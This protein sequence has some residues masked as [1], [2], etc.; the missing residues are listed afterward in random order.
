MPYK[1]KEDAKAW[2]KK[3][4]R[5]NKDNWKNPDGSWK[6]TYKDNREKRREVTNRSYY[7][8]HESISEKRKSPRSKLIKKAWLYGA[9][10]EQI[11]QL[12]KDFN[13]ECAICH[14]TIDLCV[15]H[16]DETKK[17]RGILCKGCNLLIGHAKEQIALLFEAIQY[18]Y[19]YGSKQK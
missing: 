19:K 7:K 13:Y 12:Y 17:L 16:N 10:V 11:E 15:D 6:D 14:T 4:Y 18:L 1:N 8:N 9:S 3:Y 5:A 2:G